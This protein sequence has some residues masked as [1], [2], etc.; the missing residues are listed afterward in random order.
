MVVVFSSSGDAREVVSLTSELI[1]HPSEY[2]ISL[3]P[4]TASTF[5]NEL[6]SERE[7]RTKSTHNNQSYHLSEI[8]WFVLVQRII[9]MVVLKFVQPNCPLLVKIST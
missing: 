7:N 8:V 9:Y 4:S 2:I 5:I 3:T 6:T 1:A